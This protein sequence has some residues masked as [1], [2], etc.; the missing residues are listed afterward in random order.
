MDRLDRFGRLLGLQA[1]ATV[2]DIG[3]K[4]LLLSNGTPSWATRMRRA[5][6]RYL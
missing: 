4:V 2:T 5:A 1:P 6:G 3:S